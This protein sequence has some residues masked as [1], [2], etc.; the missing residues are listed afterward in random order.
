[1]Y[2]YK[3]DKLSKSAL[4]TSIIATIL[5][6]SLMNISNVN[7][8]NIDQLDNFKGLSDIGLSNNCVSFECDNQQ[9]IDNSKTISDN[10]DSNIVSESDNTNIVTGKNST[11]L[12]ETT[13]TVTK[14]IRCEATFSTPDGAAVC[15]YAESLPVWPEPQV[16]KF[17]VNGNNP[18]PNEFTGSSTGTN[19]NLEPGEYSI[20]EDYTD[21]QFEAISNAVTA[22]DIRIG[23]TTAGDCFG[24]NP[25]TGTMTFGDSQQ[26][27][28]INT[29]TIIGGEVPQSPQ[30]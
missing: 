20:S 21:V 10:T 17:L 16:F 12:P 28:I 7:A 24:E 9:T 19:V 4:I 5:I 22:S 14:E 25:I 29:I 6:T 3:S 13:L 23:I 15:N 26:C 11:E 2:N 27:R 30:I 1:M 18:S 8:F